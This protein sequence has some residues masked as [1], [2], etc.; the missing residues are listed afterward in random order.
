M[1]RGWSKQLVVVVV[2]VVLLWFCCSNGL[3]VGRII[4]NVTLQ[5]RRFGPS[6][7][8]HSICRSR[9]GLCERSQLGLKIR[10]TVGQ[11]CHIPDGAVSLGVHK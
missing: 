1:R 2:V 9:F 10:H 7:C 3:R 11:Y 5:H 4:F 8:H 6:W